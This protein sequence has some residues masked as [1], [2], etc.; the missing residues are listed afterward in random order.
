[1]NVSR[2]LSGFVLG[3]VL[4]GACAAPPA[5]VAEVAPTAAPAPTAEGKKMEIFSW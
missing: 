5:P 4:L 3:A 1:M 2:L